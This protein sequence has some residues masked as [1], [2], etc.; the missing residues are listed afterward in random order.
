MSSETVLFVM[1]LEINPQVRHLYCH[2]SISADNP[3]E[4]SRIIIFPSVLRQI[5]GSPWKGPLL[6]ILS[7]FC[8]SQI[9]PRT[10]CAFLGAAA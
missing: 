2:F 6:N 9:P 1:R 4:G 3:N 5:Y 7:I 8:F 10:V